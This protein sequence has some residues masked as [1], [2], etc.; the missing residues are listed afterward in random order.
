MTLMIFQT[1]TKIFKYAFFFLFLLLSCSMVFASSLPFSTLL[2]HEIIGRYFIFGVLGLV[3]IFLDKFYNN[4]FIKYLVVSYFL[5]IIISCILI[6]LEF[7][8]LKFPTTFKQD[9]T[10]LPIEVFFIALFFIATAIIGIYSFFKGYERSFKICFTI[11]LLAYIYRFI[12]M[13]MAFL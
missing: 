12:L 13:Q 3:F 1:M 8:G 11:C 6:S 5:D 2:Q 9:Y 4:L 10:L 7:F